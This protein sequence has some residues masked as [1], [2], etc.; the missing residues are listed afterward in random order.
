MRSFIRHPTHIPIEYDLDSDPVLIAYDTENI[1]AGGLCF[2]AA[3]S[4]A[5]GTKIRI[6]IPCL[7]VPFKASCEV[8]WC[9]MSKPGYEIGVRFSDDENGFRLRMIEQVCYIE[10]YRLS[11]LKEENRQLTW[12]QASD[13]W[14]KKYA[15]KFPGSS[16]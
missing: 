7:D 16:G 4:I 14:I 1:S 2:K 3:K 10:E 11:V 13:E 6:R 5:E 8:V 15:E 9:K 12:K